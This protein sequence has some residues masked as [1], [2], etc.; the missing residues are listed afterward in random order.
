MPEIQII[1][2]DCGNAP[3]KLFLKNLYV[4]IAE[5]DQNHISKSFNDNV[6]WNIIG[7]KTV[8][9]KKAFLE[10]LNTHI[11]SPISKLIVHDI[12]T[13]GNEAAIHGEWHGGE[14]IALAFCDVCIFKSGGADTVKAIHTYAIA[15]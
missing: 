13:H 4:A 9:G 5:G 12:I 11:P 3:K 15:L 10:K 2:E 6:T 7:G 14:H 1:P 8:T